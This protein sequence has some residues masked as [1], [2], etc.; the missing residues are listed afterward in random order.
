MSA[1]RARGQLIPLSNL[2][3]R[4]ADGGLAPAQ[5][6]Q[7]RARHHRRRQPR[8]GRLARRRARQDGSDRARA[9]CRKKRR[10]TTRASRWTT[11]AR[12]RRIL[13]V[14]GFG[15][16]VVFLVLAAQFESWIHPFVIMLCV[17]ATVGG[18]LLGIWLTGNTLNIYTQI[19]LIMLV[20]L[21]AKNGILIVEFANQLRDEGKE[22]NAALKEAALTR[23]RPIVMTSLDGRRRR[24]PADLQPRRR[25]G[26]ALGHR[27]GDP[28]RRHHR[29][30]RDAGP[31]AGR[32]RAAGAPH[33]LAP[34]CRAQAGA[35]RTRHARP[36]RRAGGVKSRRYSA[37]NSLGLLPVQRLKARENAA[38]SEKPTR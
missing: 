31:R 30:A 38:G 10:S 29:D 20:G 35:G 26:N 21:A 34:R 27:R 25:L 36:R 15:I 12:A 1:P 17:P 37:A 32:L 11:S 6:L 2:V 28:V 14:F 16:L 8:P 5:P 4:R 33:R 22:F 13:F 3:Q 23:F 24:H 18:G 19:G 9:C 7:P